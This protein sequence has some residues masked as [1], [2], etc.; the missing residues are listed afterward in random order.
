VKGV[1]DL[2]SVNPDRR[3]PVWGWTHIDLMVVYAKS[4]LSELTMA[5]DRRGEVWVVRMSKWHE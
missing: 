3:S 1:S 2:G 5:F 4:E